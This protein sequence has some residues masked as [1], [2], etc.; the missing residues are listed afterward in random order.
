MEQEQAFL[1]QKKP[2]V[3]NEFIDKIAKSNAP[4][5]NFDIE[6]LI[7][8]SDPRSNQSPSRARKDTELLFSNFVIEIEIL[9][10]V[11]A[12][13][14][15]RVAQARGLRQRD[16][17]RH[18]RPSDL[19][20]AGRLRRRGGGRFQDERGQAE[21]ARVGPR[22][23]GGGLDRQGHAECRPCPGRRRQGARRD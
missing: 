6:Q 22:P 4:L 2:V 10:K 21:E 12:A 3:K 11:R 16:P 17:G 15:P 5:T 14:D 13:V 19:P 8:G 23:G 18:G 7:H 9:P 1:Q 20:E